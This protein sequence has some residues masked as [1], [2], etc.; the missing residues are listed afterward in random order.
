MHQKAAAIVAL[1]TLH[2]LACGLRPRDN[3]LADAAFGFVMEELDMSEEFQEWKKQFLELP[4][5]DEEQRPN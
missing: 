5:L 3:E 1:E 2:E 4:P